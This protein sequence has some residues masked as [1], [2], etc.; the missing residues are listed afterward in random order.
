MADSSTLT[1]CDEL[2]ACGALRRSAF[3][4]RLSQHVQ[5]MQPYEAVKLINSLAR[6]GGAFDLSRMLRQLLPDSG[7]AAQLLCDA[8]CSRHV[9]IALLD[10]CSAGQAAVPTGCPVQAVLQALLGVVFD[11]AAVSSMDTT[12]S[13]AAA[14]TGFAAPA[15]DAGLQQYITHVLQQLQELAHQA[16]VRQRQDAGSTHVLAACRLELCCLL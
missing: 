10:S 9:C 12:G 5:Q 16:Q 15:A 8:A 6:L 13:G 14:A 3:L 2:A 11:T 7:A 4:S 1:M